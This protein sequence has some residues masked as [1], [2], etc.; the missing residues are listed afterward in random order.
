MTITIKYYLEA[1]LAKGWGYEW[2]DEWRNIIAFYP[3]DEEPIFIRN[4][5]TELST[6]IGSLLSNYKSA[7]TV[8]AK[9]VGFLVP[10][11][12]VIEEHESFEKALPLL[13]QKNRLVV[14]PMDA[15][16]GDG[17]STNVTDAAK[18]ES[19]VENARKNNIKSPAV[20][21]QEFCAG[22]DYRLFILD[23]KV[24]AA[25]ERVPLVIQGDGEHTLDELLT[26][27]FESAQ[28]REDSQIQELKLDKTEIMDYLSDYQSDYIP[29]ANEVI[30]AHG[31]ANLSR[32]GEAIDV[33]DDVNPEIAD[34]AAKLAKLMGMT[35]CA[36][37]VL[38][39]DI[40]LTAEAG[41]TVFIE[42]NTAPG[43]RGHYYPTVGQR[44][45]LAPLILDTIIRERKAKNNL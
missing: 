15:A 33:T 25:L 34:L 11:T 36:I 27:K 13:S 17:V 38:S 28:Q 20:I 23:G 39:T 14:K 8:I 2:I 40:A 3:P 35:M 9:K 42:S 21:V 10:E 5:V 29:Q 30:R 1:A 31:V 18:L 26:V 12:L 6:S 24:E 22:R 41:Q 7:S 16:F 43:F 4:N 45:E 32:G 37:D 19:A 44:R